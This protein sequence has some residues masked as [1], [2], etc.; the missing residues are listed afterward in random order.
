MPSVQRARPSQPALRLEA[1]P[2]LPLH[3]DGAGELLPSLSP[4]SLSQAQSPLRS[5]QCPAR[6]GDQWGNEPPRSEI[7]VPLSARAQARHSTPACDPVQSAAIAAIA[8]IYPP[9][10]TFCERPRSRWRVSLEQNLA[11]PYE[12]G[13]TMG[14]DC[15]GRVLG[16][17]LSRPASTRADADLNRPCFPRLRHVCGHWRLYGVHVHVQC[18][19]P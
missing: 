4:L 6:A 8:A 17:C 14:L 3:A 5:S 13:G 18:L 2:R 19:L 10:H 12:G 7:V 9:A 1:R 15:G 11:V 16:V